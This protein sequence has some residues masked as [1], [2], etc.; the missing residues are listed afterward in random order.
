[1]A[2]T[3]ERVRALLTAAVSDVEV[4]SPKSHRRILY[5]CRHYRHMQKMLSGMGGL[6]LALT[7]SLGM[8]LALVGQGTTE[9][10]TK[11]VEHP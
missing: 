9:I 5:H 3:G 1:M 6:L 2:P 11:R 4:V 7:S 10:P 8:R